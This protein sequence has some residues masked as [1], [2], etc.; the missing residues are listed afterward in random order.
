MKYRAGSSATVNQQS[1][2]NS[3]EGVLID[4]TGDLITPY[5]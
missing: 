2:S 3:N 4:V 1:S 5:R